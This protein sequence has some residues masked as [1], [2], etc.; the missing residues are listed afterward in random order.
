MIENKFLRVWSIAK[1][2]F[3]QIRRDRV[4]FLWLLF[5]PAI[6]IL[7]FGFII[8]TDPKNLPTTIISSEDTPF[9]RSLLE[10]LKNTHYFSINTAAKDE[11]TA[12]RLLLSGKSLFIINIPPN[13]SRNL[14][15]EQYPHVLIEAD[16]SDPLTVANAF[17]AASELPARVFEHDL[18]GSLEYLAPK[19]LPFDFEVHAKFNPENI[20]QYNT[21]PGLIAYLIFATFTV[22]TAVSINS[23]FERGTF[24]ALLITPLT[25]G[26]II[27]GKVIPHFILAY[28]LFF[29]LLA[30]AYFIFSIPFYGS[31]P[32]YLL[33][34]APYS[35]S[36]IGTGL[37]ISALTKSQFTA[38]SLSNAYILIATLISGFLFPFNGIPHWAQYFSQVMPLT[39]F[40]R[41][42]RNSMLK[43]A[44]LDILW[45]DTWPIILFTVFIIFLAILLFR[46]TLD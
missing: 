1:K 11:K 29:V 2:E 43:G 26:N 8:N 40:L 24:E 28:L 41:I 20:P 9:T 14:I 18:H 30:I 36:N 19:D 23:E 21:I 42:T 35:I 3:I 46:R 39:H 7:L 13:F 44:D 15:R 17:R 25:P 10:G 4:V 27:F 32:L 31:F 12:E 6:Q 16:A 33:L 37:A 5:A 22:L 45:P 34:L 38:V